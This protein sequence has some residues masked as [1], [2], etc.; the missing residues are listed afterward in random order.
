MNK[1]NLITSIKGNIDNAILELRGLV[2]SAYESEDERVSS[3]LVKHGVEHAERYLDKAK[4]D[5]TAVSVIRSELLEIVAELVVA[6]D[7]TDDDLFN[8][9]ADNTIDNNTYIEKLEDTMI[10]IRKHAFKAL[11][12]LR[13]EDRN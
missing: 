5:L 6:Y 3:D 12:V 9:N 4:R 2:I 13:N 11:E 10:N 7:P 1:G 8:I